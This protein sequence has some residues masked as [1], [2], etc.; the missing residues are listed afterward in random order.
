[1]VYLPDSLVR[2]IL[3]FVTPEHILMALSLGNKMMRFFSIFSPFLNFFLSSVASFIFQSNIIHV[4]SWLSWGFLP[5]NF[6]LQVLFM[7]AIST[8]CLSDPARMSS[9]YCVDNRYPCS[10]KHLLCISLLLKPP[11]QPED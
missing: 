6:S 4:I 8:Q 7:G 5:F 1:M 11:R 10:R 3:Y 2:G 9:L